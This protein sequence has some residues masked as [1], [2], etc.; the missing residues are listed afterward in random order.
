M[1]QYM[2]CI[3]VSWASSHLVYISNGSKSFRFA[4]GGDRLD[5]AR[6]S[7]MLDELGVVFFVDPFIPGL[8]I[9]L[10][11]RGNTAHEFQCKLGRA[12]AIA[13]RCLEGCRGIRNGWRNAW[14]CNALS[15][16][17]CTRSEVHGAAAYSAI[18]PVGPSRCH[19]LLPVTSSGHF[20]DT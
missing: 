10:A 3:L 1:K 20:S 14:S 19:V 18:T 13:L 12:R 4:L 5:C 7:S 16:A 9:P 6:H 8:V 15:G 17:P 11:L 2:R